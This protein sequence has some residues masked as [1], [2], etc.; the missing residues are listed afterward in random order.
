M[1][2]QAAVF[3]PCEEVEGVCLPAAGSQLPSI[4]PSVQGSCGGEGTVREVCYWQA[5]RKPAALKIPHMKHT[6]QLAEDEKLFFVGREHGMARAAAGR[7]KDVLD[8][9]SV[10]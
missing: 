2:G 5:R 7:Q 1:A 9:K 10:V 8:R 6:A 4:L 3:F